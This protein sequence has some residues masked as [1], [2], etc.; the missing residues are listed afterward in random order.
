MLKSPAMAKQS[1]SEEIV[2]S[3]HQ[4][5]LEY[6]GGLKIM[7]SKIRGAPFNTIPRYSKDG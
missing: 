3:S 4:Q 6:F 2:D 5:M 7:I 1:N